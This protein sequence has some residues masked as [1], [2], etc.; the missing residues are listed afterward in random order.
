MPAPIVGVA[1]AAAARIAAKKIAQKKVKERLGKA[2]MTKTGKV[3]SNSVKPVK[4]GAAYAKTFNQGSMMRTTDAATGAAA[5]KGAARLGVTG[6]KGVQPPVKIRTQQ[7]LSSKNV[8]DARGLKAANKPVSKNN[9]GQTASKLK[10]DILKR[11]TPARAN[12]TRLGK[13]ALKSK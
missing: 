5:R 9:S 4:A 7:N 1:I 12:R 10:V 13:I 6:K 2:G 3:V 11:A 8:K